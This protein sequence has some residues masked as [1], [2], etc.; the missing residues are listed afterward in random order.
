MYVIVTSKP[1]PIIQE[2]QGL[3]RCQANYLLRNTI[4][5]AYHSFALE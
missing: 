4:Q 2:I 1:D 5:Y 3:C